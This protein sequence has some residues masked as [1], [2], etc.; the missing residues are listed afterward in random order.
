[1]RRA[2]LKTFVLRGS[3]RRDWFF[4]FFFFFP[5]LGAEDMRHEKRLGACRTQ[6]KPYH[7]YE[8][9][10]DDE[11]EADEQ[12]AHHVEVMRPLWL[13]GFHASHRRVEVVTISPCGVISK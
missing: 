4:L 11:D 9:R 7:V 5:K 3:C 1:M 10:R 12:L 6:K 13:V 8:E 2:G